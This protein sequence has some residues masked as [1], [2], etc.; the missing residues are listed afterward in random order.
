MSRAYPEFFTEG[1]A[2]DEWPKIETEGRQR[3]WIFGEGAA[4]TRGRGSKLP[5]HQL[6]E[7]VGELRAPPA[8]FGLLR[9]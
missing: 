3:E 6:G 5:P 7:S 4:S 2:K 8:G 1:Q 9:L